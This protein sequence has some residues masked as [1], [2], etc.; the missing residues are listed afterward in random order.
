MP[1]AENQEAWE[2][3]KALKQDKVTLKRDIAACF[4]KGSIKGLELIINESDWYFYP[5]YMLPPEGRW[6]KGGVFL[7]GD[8]AHAMPPQGESTGI[9]I[10][11]GVLFAHVLGEGIAK[12]VPYV[13]EA[14]EV[15]RRH[16]IEKMHA[17]TMFRW[18][19][20]SSPSWPW[21]LLLGPIFF[22]PTID[23]KITLNGM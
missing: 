17:E 7:L 19:A 9:A 14:C 20:G 11:G 13:T 21:N 5:V 2:E 6:S 4:E 15:L 18:N 12:G 1:M 8:A 3:W 10:E 23:R 16:G 22:F